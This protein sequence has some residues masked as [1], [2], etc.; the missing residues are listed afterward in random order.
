MLK[1]LFAVWL[2][3]LV[4]SLSALAG[5]VPTATSMTADQL[6]RKNIAARGGESAWQQVVSMTMTGRM[7]VGQGMQ[8][9]YTM[10]LKRGRKVRVEILFAGKTAVQVYDGTNGWK[11]R[12]F[13]GRSD[14]EPYTAEERQ[15]AAMD[16]DIDGL[17]IGYA[18]KGTK[19]QIENVEKVEGHDAYKVKLTLKGGQERRVWIDAESYLELKID[20]TRRLDGKQKVVST[21]FHDYRTVDGLRIPFVYETAVDG[22]KTS[23]RI[24]VE[25]IVVNSK[26]DDTLF[27]RLR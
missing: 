4:S 26:L 27:A 19:A 8:V 16:S 7:D 24:D 5:G 2:F 21:Y 15:K 6:I 22:V 12:P 10:E 13:L 25:K 17:L 18:A 1:R 9:P 11:L 20:G 23:E 3:L 14:V